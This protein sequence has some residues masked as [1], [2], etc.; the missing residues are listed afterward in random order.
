MMATAHIVRDVFCDA[1]AQIPSQPNL[2]CYCNPGTSSK[3]EV[4]RATATGTENW[5]GVQ[6]CICTTWALRSRELRGARGASLKSLLSNRPLVT[7]DH[8]CVAWISGYSVPYLGGGFKST[9]L[10]PV[11]S[12]RTAPENTHSWERGGGLPSFLPTH[13]SF[14]SQQPE[15]R[16]Y[17][18]KLVPVTFISSSFKRPPSLHL[19]IHHGRTR[20]IRI[21]LT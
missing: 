10:Y 14:R 19:S 20:L 6:A 18:G 11:V 21:Q 8:V 15:H 5:V 13:Q 1:Q 7:F 9:S 2:L 12:G 17:R 3:M 16:T 4:T